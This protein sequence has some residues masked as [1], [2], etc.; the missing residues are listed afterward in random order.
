MTPTLG[1]VQKSKAG[2][3]CCTSN[4]NLEPFSACLHLFSEAQRGGFYSYIAGTAYRIVTAHEVGGL[5]I[6]NYR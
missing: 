2:C 3:F 1:L 4:L 6:D 5:R